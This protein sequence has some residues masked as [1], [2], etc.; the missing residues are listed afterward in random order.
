MEH[1]LAGGA[2]EVSKDDLQIKC[3]FILPSCDKWRCLFELQ[4][5][6]ARMYFYP[7]GLAG[8]CLI[9]FRLLDVSA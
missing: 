1:S 4:K 5:V 6:D 2:S 7:N 9:L 8:K 3:F